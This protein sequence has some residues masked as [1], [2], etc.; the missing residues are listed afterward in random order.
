MRSNSTW[1]VLSHFERLPHCARS[2]KCP[3]PD[4]GRSHVERAKTNQT[5]HNSPDL[6]LQW[7]DPTCSTLST[8]LLRLLL[9]FLPE[10]TVL[11]PRLVIVALP[12]AKLPT[13]RD[14]SLLCKPRRSP[15]SPRLSCLLSEVVRQLSLSKVINEQTSDPLCAPLVF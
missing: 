4:S 3:Q 11:P 6:A 8:D 15:S 5:H 9:K 7:P 10:T 14:V 2:S 12:P 13:L 1:G